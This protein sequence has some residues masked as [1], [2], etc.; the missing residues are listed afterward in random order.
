MGVE[1]KAGGGADLALPRTGVLVDPKRDI[2]EIED[3]ATGYQ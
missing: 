2:E 3:F 1:S